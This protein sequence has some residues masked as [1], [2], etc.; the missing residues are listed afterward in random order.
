M[1]IFIF[2][3]NSN[4]RDWKV[5]FVFPHNFPKSA[6]ALKEEIRRAS[7]GSGIFFL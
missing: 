1:L 2:K 4:F 5:F 6:E 7:A 3:L